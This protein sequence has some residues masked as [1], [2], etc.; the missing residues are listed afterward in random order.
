[1]LRSIGACWGRLLSSPNSS[2]PDAR[3]LKLLLE[4]QNSESSSDD[5]LPLSVFIC[6]GLCMSLSGP[7]AGP[8][9][10]GRQLQAPDPAGSMTGVI[11]LLGG[12]PLVC[13]GADRRGAVRGGALRAS[14]SGPGQ[15]LGATKEQGEHAVGCELTISDWRVAGYDVG[16]VVGW[17]CSTRSAGDFPWGSPPLPKSVG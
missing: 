17:E 2:G 5:V 14:G 8:G 13:R 7:A 15:G 12:S 11:P 1:M 6:K 16:S 4:C 10:P 3:C 9:T